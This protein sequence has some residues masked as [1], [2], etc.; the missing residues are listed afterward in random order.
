MSIKSIIVQE[1]AASPIGIRKSRKL[2]TR[3]QILEAAIR[4]F[5][6]EGILAASTAEV[7]LEAGVAHGSVFAHFGTQEGL[8]V[9][10]IE[11]FGSALS[12]RIHELVAKGAGT[13]EVLQAHLEAIREREDFYA[14]LVTEAPLLPEE[15]RHSLVLIQ[16]TIAFHLSPAI[17]KDAKEGRIEAMSL[18]L[19]FNTWLGLLH[20][21]LA[22]RELF[23]PGSS[24]VEKRG[25]ELLDHFMFLVSARNGRRRGKGA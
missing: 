10:A 15:A 7:A 19:L 4:V 23:A 18:P 3:R 2:A 25:E 24:L 20:Y 11:D 17:A 13:R 1:S 22:N 6:R 16:S 5:G 8:I 21:Y 12:L 14:R 9:A